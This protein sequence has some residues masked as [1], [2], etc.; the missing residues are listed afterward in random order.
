M[1]MAAEKFV[2]SGKC[3]DECRGKLE[4]KLYRAITILIGITIFVV[5]QVR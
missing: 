4:P 2:F 1:G 5:G 3:G